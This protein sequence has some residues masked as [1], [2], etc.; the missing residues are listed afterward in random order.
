[1]SR[2][3]PLR[4]CWY[5]FGGRLPDDYRE[6][7]RQ[8][9]AGPHWLRRHLLRVLVQAAPVVL[10]AVLLLGWLTPVPWWMIGAVLAAGLLMSAFLT[11][12][13]ARELNK[14]RLVKHG[15]PPES[16]SGSSE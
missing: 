2:P 6:W 11:A 16:M 12:G 5:A 1:M 13:M 8:D 7:V 9:A 14:A 15:L 3:G 4:W 10:V